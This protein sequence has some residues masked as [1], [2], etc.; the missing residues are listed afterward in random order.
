MK[1]L[2]NWIVALLFVASA[3]GA[4]VTVAETAAPAPSTW[5]RIAAT[6]SSSAPGST[7]S[8]T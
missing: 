6:C 7:T 5:L 3:G 1:T 8:A 2:R 4:T